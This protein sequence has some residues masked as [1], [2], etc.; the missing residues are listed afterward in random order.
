MHLDGFTDAKFNAISVIDCRGGGI[1]LV[2]PGLRSFT[3]HEPCRW[4]RLA[5]QSCGSSG[6]ASAYR[7]LHQALDVIAARA[8][9][10]HSKDIVGHPA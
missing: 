6:I 5:G 10:D 9:A 7:Y 2:A 8:D 1:C 4:I 3:G